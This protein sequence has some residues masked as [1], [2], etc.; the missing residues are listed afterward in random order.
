MRRASCSDMAR[1]PDISAEAMSE[2][3]TIRDAHRHGTTWLSP[4]PIARGPTER[5]DEFIHAATKPASA[6]NV[7]SVTGHIG[8]DAPSSQRSW[9]FAFSRPDGNGGSNG[10]A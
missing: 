1:A 7:A 3:E 6:C 9:C 10:G 4:S 5:S 2:T 8:E